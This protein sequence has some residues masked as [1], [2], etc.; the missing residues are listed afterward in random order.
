MR[1]VNGGVIRRLAAIA[2]GCVLVTIFLLPV[3]AQIYT[4]SISGS[5]VDASGGVVSG[6]KVTLQTGARKLATDTSEAGSFVFLGL[7]PGHYNLSVT[8]SGFSTLDQSDIVLPAG[9]R[10]SL[11]TISLKV[12][13]T[14][15]V[16]TVEAQRGTVQTE[17]GERVGN[18]TNRQLQDLLIPSRSIPSLVGLLPGVVMTNEQPNLNRTTTFS[19]LGGRTDTNIISV[20]GMQSTDLDN[21]TDL[22][23]Q[24][25]ETPYPRCRS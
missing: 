19:A 9:E 15:E 21:G 11:G 23:L 4:G 24:I 14:S 25:S 8:K 3:K 5:V 22:K 13:A 2:S 18:L 1:R 10:L 17:G 20:D 6:A 16:V 12:G 7:E